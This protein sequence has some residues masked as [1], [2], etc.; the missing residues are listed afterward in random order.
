MTEAIAQLFQLETGKA[1][2]A[3]RTDGLRVPGEV[4]KIG[5]VNM[6]LK[7][8]QNTIVNTHTN[9]IKK[10]NIT[11]YGKLVMGECSHFLG[12]P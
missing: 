4:H 7:T 2:K 6:C 5:L 12:P 11:M 3:Q 10:K 8:Q 9:M 1:A